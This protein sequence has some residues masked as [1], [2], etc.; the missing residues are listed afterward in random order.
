MTHGAR[1]RIGLLWSPHL[2]LG[3]RNY[4]R[5]LLV[6]VESLPDPEIELVVFA[7]IKDDSVVAGLK[8]TRVVRSAMLERATVPWLL[9]QTVAKATSQDWMLQRS[10]LRQGIE[11][12]THGSPLVSNSSIP[13]IGWIPD[14]QEMHL[15]ALFSAQERRT[16]EENNMALCSKCDKVIVSSETA[17]GDFRAFAPLYAHK[18]QVL[19]FTATPAASSSI[20]PMAMLADR[21][22]IRGPFFLLPNQFWA[23]KNHR[24]VIAALSILKDLG[25][26]VVVL[27]TGRT[28]DDRQPEFFASLMSYAARSD[29]LDHFRVL[30]EIPFA[31]LTGLMHHAVALINPSSF[32]GW[33]T[34]VE[35]SK[36][37]G[38]RIVLSDLPVHR[39][40]A[41]ALGT[42]FPPDDADALASALWNTLRDFDRDA[43][44]A[45]QASASAGL[46]G[47]QRVFARDF[48]SIMKATLN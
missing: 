19:R 24:V 44:L 9:R 36:S 2:W 5:N 27:C 14:F 17:A 28:R 23:H 46:L 43:D 6:A 29:V 1:T 41:P 18:V 34:S 15:P 4:F 3:G 25:R 37:L 20:P 32:E 10:L 38:K 30:G 47:R 8:A 12:L 31:D 42:F 16:R 13:S 11:V 21:Y 39:E 33:S 40:Q 35:E 45:A 26:P 48:Q 22:D 7:S